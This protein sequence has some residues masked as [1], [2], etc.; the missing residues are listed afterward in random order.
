MF[1]PSEFVGGFLRC[2]LSLVL[3]TLEYSFMKVEVE[4]SNFSV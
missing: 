3:L 4:A 1:F 2:I